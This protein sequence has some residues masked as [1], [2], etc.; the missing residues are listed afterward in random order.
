MHTLKATLPTEHSSPH[1]LVAI[2]EQT[3]GKPAPNGSGWLRIPSG[4]AKSTS[5]SIFVEGMEFLGLLEKQEVLWS[6]KKKCKESVA[7]ESGVSVV[8]SG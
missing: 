3:M 8:P 5:N 4:P 6:Q 2:S 7:L 1:T